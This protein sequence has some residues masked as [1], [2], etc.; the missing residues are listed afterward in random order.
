[1]LDTFHDCNSYKHKGLIGSRF[2]VIYI[3]KWYLVYVEV[4]FRP[5][6]SKLQSAVVGFGLYEPEA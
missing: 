4:F 3:L 6:D 1:M 2:I 5:I